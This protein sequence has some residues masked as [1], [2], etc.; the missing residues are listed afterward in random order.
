LDKQKGARWLSSTE[1]WRRRVQLARW[2]GN[3]GGEVCGDETLG[4]EG[5]RG[6][7]SPWVCGPSGAGGRT[8]KGKSRLAAQMEMEMGIDDPAGRGGV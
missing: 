7:L 8:G 5:V 2:C 1:A 4:A 3:R 6:R